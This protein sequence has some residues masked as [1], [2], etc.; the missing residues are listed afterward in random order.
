MSSIHDWADLAIIAVLVMVAALLRRTRRSQR[1]ECRVQQRCAAHRS[2]R[3]KYLVTAK[4]VD[5]DEQ[6]GNDNQPVGLKK[7]EAC[8]QVARHI[9]VPKS[10]SHPLSGQMQEG[11]MPVL[12]QHLPLWERP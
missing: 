7:A 4:Q 11:E 12:A 10:A 5:D 8:Q 2:G 1:L 6:V 3:V 9:V